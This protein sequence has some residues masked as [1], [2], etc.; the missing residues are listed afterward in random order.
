MSK[1]EE[2]SA[3][4]GLTSNEQMT[5]YYPGKIY[6]QYSISEALN[7]SAIT[8]NVYF[9]LFGSLTAI[10]GHSCK[11]VP[12]SDQSHVSD[13]QHDRDSSGTSNMQFDT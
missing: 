4:F 13:L 9:Q 3:S 2:L 10:L 11:R 1:E 7:F 8:G 5:Y 6:L 12:F